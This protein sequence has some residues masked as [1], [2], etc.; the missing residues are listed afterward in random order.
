[1]SELAFS[2]FA[3]AVAMLV[4]VYALGLLQRLYRSFRKQEKSIATD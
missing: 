2:I 4:W 1:M 3:I